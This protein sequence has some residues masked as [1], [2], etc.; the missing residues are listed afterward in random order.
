[1]PDGYTPPEP[2]SVVLVGSEDGIHDTVI[3]WLRAAGADLRRVHVFAGRAASGVWKGLPTFPEDCGL[4][5]ETLRE[6]GA[7]LLIVDPLLA[8]LSNRVCSQALAPLAQVAKET[9]AALLL[10]RH[11]TKGGR[12]AHA[13]YRGS[14][15]IAIIGAARMAYL[16]GAPATDE[17]LH[18]LACTKSNLATP[19]ASLSFR[20]T[21]TDRDQPVVCW[22]GAVELS[23]DD[24]VLAP[25]QAYGLALE[26]AKE[27]LQEQ[28]RHGPC[29]REDLRQR[30]QDAGVSDSTLRRAQ[31]VL[32]VRSEPKYIDGRNCWYWRL[33]GP[34]AAADALD[35]PERNRRELAQA[36][37]ESDEL[38]VRLCEKYGDKPVA[39]QRLP[40]EPGT[41]PNP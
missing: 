30:A 9:Q 12:G 33:P 3:P 23:A 29:A 39:A 17:D 20:I 24:L 22:A 1:L 25:R 34:V 27:F 21:R 40:G 41:Q 36:Q 8:F 35:W 14:G 10:V 15:S 19:P 31:A 6:T 28:L 11:L 4:L 38:L 2:Q 7:R 32:G 5:A 26:R 16:V 37:K 18:V 13:L